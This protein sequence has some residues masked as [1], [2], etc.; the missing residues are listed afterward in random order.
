MKPSS[1]RA[2]WLYILTMVIYG[3]IGVFRRFIPL[4]SGALAFIRGLVGGVCLLGFVKLRGGKLF[5]GLSKR[6]ILLLILSGAML[7]IN[8]MLLFEA[9][10]HTTVAVATLCYYMQPTFLI[11]L[12]PLVFREALTLRKGLCAAVAVGGMTLVSGVFGGSAAESSLAGIL[13][14][15]GAAALYTA[16]VILNKKLAVENAYGQTVI[17]LLSA[18]AVMVPYLLL[19]ESACAFPTDP[20]ALLMIAVVGIVHT[21]V[22]YAMYF[23]SIGKLPSQTVAVLGYID[24]VVALLLSAL[25]LREPMTVWQTAGAV[26]ILLATAVSEHRSQRT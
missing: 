11:L 2:V 13:F 3:S 1:S 25:L 4:S 24:P 8:W 14:G 7:G 12:S 10:N 20:V 26:M 9:Y 19:T 23:S 17:Q 16:I 5:F 6:G 21:G 18:A 15:L 22:A